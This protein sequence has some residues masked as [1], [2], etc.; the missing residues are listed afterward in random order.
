MRQHS[1]SVDG[2]FAFKIENV[3]GK[4]VIANDKHWFRFLKAAEEERRA[5]MLHL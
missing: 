3:G 5:E 2:C 4:N 1:Y